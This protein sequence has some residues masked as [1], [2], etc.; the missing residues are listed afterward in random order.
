M[1]AMSSVAFIC[2]KIKASQQDRDRPIPSD[3]A[4]HAQGKAQGQTA[5]KNADRVRTR[6]D[7][8]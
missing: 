7:A 4:G 3:Q 1:G 6:I 5:I 8:G 2:E